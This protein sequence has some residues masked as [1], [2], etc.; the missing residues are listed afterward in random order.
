[1]Y[2]ITHFVFQNYLQFAA[3]KYTLKTVIFLHVR[4]V[5]H[6]FKYTDIYI[7]TMHILYMCVFDPWFKKSSCKMLERWEDGNFICSKFYN[8]CDALNFKC[9]SLVL[10]V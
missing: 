6:P 5:R 10:A 3:C 9:I 8:F 1:M 4:I 2:Y 7:N